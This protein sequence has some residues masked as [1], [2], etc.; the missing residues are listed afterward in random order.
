[1]YELASPIH[2]VNPACP[3]TLISQGTHDAVVPLDAARRLHQSLEAA[4]VPVVYVEYPWTEHAFDVMY[5]PLANPAAKAELYG[6]ERFLVAVA[7]TSRKQ[8]PP[9]MS[10]IPWEPAADDQ[11]AS[12]IPLSPQTLPVVH[13]V[14]IGQS[15]PAPDT[16]PQKCP[17]SQDDYASPTSRG[18]ECL[19]P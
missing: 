12:V 7:N 15:Q 16:D 18:D 14:H 8:E 13:S 9:N 10:Q 11:R 5:P 17:R 4:G 3:P 1:M 19:L 2:H 6:L